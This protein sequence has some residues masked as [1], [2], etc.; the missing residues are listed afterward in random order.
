MGRNIN[1]Y[2]LALIEQNK[3]IYMRAREKERKNNT[4]IRKTDTEIG[5]NSKQANPKNSNS[6]KEDSVAMIAGVS[7]LKQQPK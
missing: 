4:G 5:E 7:S 2:I 1:W 6:V 3:E